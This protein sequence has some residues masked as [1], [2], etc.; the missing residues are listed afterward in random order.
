MRYNILRILLGFILIF[1]SLFVMFFSKN[2]NALLVV[3][4]PIVYAG[5]Y[6]ISTDIFTNFK[7]PGISVINVICIIRY[8][9]IPFFILMDGDYVDET[10]LLNQGIWL[11]LY[12]QICVWFFLTIMT[13]RGYKRLDKVDSYSVLA[14]KFS[15][16][17]GWIMTGFTLLGIVLIMLNPSYLNKFNFSLGMTR[18]TI[19]LYGEV[20]AGLESI[21]LDWSKIILPLVLANIFI[22]RYRR[23][24]KEYLYYLTVF[25]VL[26]FN[27][28]IFMGI[29]RASALLPGIACLFFFLKLFPE[30]KTKTMVLISTAIIV[31][32]VTLT[33][34]KNAYIGVN[35]TYTFSSFT[36]YLQSYFVG[37]TNLAYSII[38]ND[39]YG[40]SFSWRTFMN[41]IFYGIP[42]MSN[43]FEAENR[44]TTLF[45]LTVYQ[46]GT[47]RDQIIP[48]IGQGLFYFGY[49]FSIL[50]VLLLIWLTTK[51]DKMFVESNNTMDAFLYAF[52]A[53]S[54]GYFCF[55][56]VSIAASTAGGKV[57]PGMFLIYLNKKLNLVSKRNNLKDEENDEKTTVRSK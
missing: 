46:G 12:E 11:M 32:A 38:A 54:F 1:L 57:I 24:Q 47:S 20:V 17:S 15:T 5:L 39:Q 25:I 31:V 8:V 6:M 41:D 13:K 9:I 28:M 42:G 50:P 51:L 23:Y 10:G 55:Q 18:S 44:T 26:F 36:K 52:F 49:V 22:A 2:E 35:E 29:S 37:P 19:Y 43:F 4:A 56:N 3:I 34:Y 48:T 16:R 33:L 7:Y 27:I 14:G 53:V 30:K 45:N 21:I 40:V